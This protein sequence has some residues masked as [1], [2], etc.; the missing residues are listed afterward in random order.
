MMLATMFVSVGTAS[1]STDNMA[2]TIPAVGSSGSGVTLGTVRITETTSS[3]G[4]ITGTPGAPQQITINLPSG[5]S[6]DA[7]PGLIATGTTLANA[8]FAKY[9]SANTAFLPADITFVAGSTK[10]LTFQVEGRGGAGAANAAAISVLF[11]SLGAST[12]TLDAPDANIAVEIYAPN[13]GVTQGKVINATS[14]SAGT[15]ATVMDTSTVANGNKKLVGTIRIAETRANSVKGHLLPTAKW[16]AIKIVAPD[17]VTF[18]NAAGIPTNAAGVNYANINM[19]NWTMKT[20]A[21]ADNADGYSQLTMTV[22]ETGLGTTP[23]FVNVDV[24]VDIT[25]RDLTG[26]LEFT[27]K[28]D[29]VTTQK[30]TLGKVSDYSVEVV[31]K[32]DPKTVKAGFS[33]QELQKLTI[34]EGLKESFVDNR[35]FVLELP[36]WAHW[37]QAPTITTELGNGSFTMDQTGINTYD[38]QRNKLTFTYTANPAPTKTEF[39]FEDLKVFIDPDA[40]EGD[41][42]VIADGKGLGGKFEAVLGKVVKPINATAAKADVKIGLTNQA[43]P[44]ITITEAAAGMLKYQVTTINNGWDKDTFTTVA[45]VST[46][47]QLD[48]PDG[49]TF[50]KTPTVKVTAGDLKIKLDDVELSNN[51][52]TLDIPIDKTSTVA[53]TIVVSDIAYTLNRTVP[54]GDVTVS[55]TGNAVDCTQDSNL[56]FDDACVKIVNATT[57]TPAPGEIGNTTVFTFGSTTYKMNGIEKTMDVAPY[58][59]DN[60]T[61]MPIRYVA[62]ALGIDDANI[63]WDQVNSTVTLMKGDKVVQMKIGSKSI[64]INGAT[65]T[66]DVAPEATANR[67]MLPAALVA[68]AFGQTATWDAAANTVTIK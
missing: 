34:K 59:K 12:V 32:G 35:D 38:N 47:L 56:A 63:L 7:N 39:T 44:D 57:I 24:V 3:I 67:T 65:I 26:A 4:S 31:A 50:S 5:V 10:S 33:N 25:D 29:N 66:M 11:N 9:L 15:T 6:Y 23:G 21:V 45:N 64:L 37:Y 43:A 53:G 22:N 62:Y 61:Y 30:V 52:N 20:A 46:I 68:Q 14:S 51:D 8:T 54:E 1:A 55:L 60:R 13:S 42:K 41:L 36:T 48:L 16:D 17:D 27:V 28:G 19:A 58:A 40:P 18:T 2:L 49:V